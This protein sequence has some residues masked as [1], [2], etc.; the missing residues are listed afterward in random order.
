[1]KRQQWAAATAGVLLL[2][3]LLAAIRNMHL[4]ALDRFLAFLL[5]VRSLLVNRLAGLAMK[6]KPSVDFSGYWRRQVIEA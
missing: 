2:A 5:I 1:L 4:T 6:Q 3:D